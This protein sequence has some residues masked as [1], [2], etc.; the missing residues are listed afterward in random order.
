MNNSGPRPGSGA[1]DS[2]PPTTFRLL[3]DY[4]LLAASRWRAPKERKLLM[5]ARRQ[6]DLGATAQPSRYSAPARSAPPR[7][8]AN[9]L[10]LILIFP[11]RHLITSRHV[12]L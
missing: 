10:S 6:I 2:P 12:E 11:F 3:F 5:R 8:P 4:A 9:A 1:R 7:C